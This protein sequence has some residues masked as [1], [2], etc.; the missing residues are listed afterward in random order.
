M[1][2]IERAIDRLGGGANST[3]ELPKPIIEAELPIAKVGK[4]AESIV[5]KT[6]SATSATTPVATT[7]IG[8]EPVRAAPR[9]SDVNRKEPVRLHLESMRLKGLLTPD[10]KQSTT[11]EEFRVIK[12]PLI[13]NAFG[14]GTAPVRNGKRIMVTSAFPGEGKSFCAINLAMSIAAERDQKVLLIDA[15]VARPSIPRE[16]GIS[17]EAGLMDWLIDG[18]LD[19]ADL[20]LAT[21]VDKLSIL[22][23]GRRHQ[24]ATEL[25][26]STSMSRLLEQISSRYPDRICIFDSPPLLVTTEARVL[27]SYMG[28]IVMVVEAGRTPR[29]IVMEAL[30]TI[31]S[32]EVI[33]LV[34]NKAKKIESSGYYGYGYGAA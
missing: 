20:V 15:D 8:T 6:I 3:P 13:A 19:V 18:K 21:N 25:L 26:A 10:S 1:S 2:L 7:S 33:G 22:P 12:R 28:Q 23:A 30:S 16:L 32:N 34:L 29:D 4:P 17:A 24:S 27:A 5:N 11:G 14:K 9:A 31:E